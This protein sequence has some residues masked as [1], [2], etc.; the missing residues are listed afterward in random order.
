MARPRALDRKL[1]RDLWRIRVQAAAIA[2]LVACAVAVLAGS[3]AIWRAL[4]RSQAR[5]YEANRFA[6]VFAEA[7]RAPEPL[8]AELAALPGVAEVETRVVAGA[9]LALPGVD[10]AVTARL[11][12]VSPGG[13]RLNRPHVRAGRALAPGAVDEVLV[14]EGFALA[15][16]LGPGDVLEAVVNGRRQRLTVVG[17]AISPDTVYAIPPGALFPDDRHYGV[18]WAPRDALAAAMD[19]EGAFSEVSLL[20]GPGARTDEVVAGVDRLLAPAGGLGAHGRDRHVSHRFLSD[21]IA[22]LRT[23]AAVVPAIFLGVAAFLV[24]VVLSRLVGTQRRQIGMLKALGYGTRELAAHYAKLVLAVAAA[25]CLLGAAGGRLMAGAMART[26][27]DFYRLP[28]VVL[29]GDAPVVLL[30]CALALA[31]SLAG[32]LGALRAVVALPP[33]EAMR[34]AAPP[35]YHATLL[36]RLGLAR[37]LAPAG[38]MVLRDLGRRPLRA[39]LSALGLACAVAILVVSWF[40]GDAIDVLFDR[41]LVRAQRDDVTVTFTHAL[42]EAA[43][44]ELGRLPGVRRVEALRAWPATLRAGPRSALAALSGV[45]GDADLSRLVDADGR[46]VPTPPAGLVLSR[47]LADDLGVGRGGAV[48]AEVKDGSRPIRSLPVVAVV[49]DFLGLQA[50]GDRGWLA[51]ALGEPPL[52]SGARLAVDAAALPELQRR[53]R[54]VPAVAGVTLRAATLAAYDALVAGLLL[55]YMAV[56]SAL[57]LAIAA[58]VVY[59]TARVTW[60]E[61]EREL[62]TLRVIGFTRGEVWRVLAGELAVHVA[63]AV[64]A[65]WAL[66]LAAVLLTARA[67]ETDLYRLPV[68]VGRATYATAALVVAAGAAA[69]LLLALRWVR[70]LDLVEVLKSRE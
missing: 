48:T 13:A 20:L 30:A 60:A 55:R 70:D 64:P 52:A 21:E 61:R 44:L 32:G 49:E 22:Q 25:G 51:Q 69:V 5:Y 24:S 36:E 57:A 4:A 53:L 17:V 34:P 10:E 47:R 31:G 67:A 3:A 40:T 39:L 56:I 68:V 62:A 29:E 45:D 9:T 6:H 14:S 12:S 16:H 8:A 18:V 42:P 11:L 2:V 27:A 1:L 38:R 15:R 59:N 66:G 7:W 41:T 19:L 33:A 28:A 50:T 26:Y 54:A 46:V 63:A 43:L 37:L 35:G 58:G 65:G 23:M